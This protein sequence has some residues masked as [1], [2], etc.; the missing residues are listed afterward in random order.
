MKASKLRNITAVLAKIMEII[1][2]VAVGGIS[3]AIVVILALRDKIL[4][5]Y[6]QENSYLTFTASGFDFEKLSEAN[7]IPSMVGLLIT[8]IV[9]GVL[10]AFM[11]RSIH[12]IFT[13]TNTESPFTQSNVVLVKRIGY[14]AIAMPVVKL[15]ANIILGLISRDIALEIEFSEVLFG[16]VILCLS[17]Y[18]SYGASLE[19][20]VNGLL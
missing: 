14:I 17:Q 10:T 9:L 19:K 1:S 4:E 5:V 6:F 15:V 8:S 18:F 12:L 16:L 11:F 20:D 7:L 2:W 13:K 3:I